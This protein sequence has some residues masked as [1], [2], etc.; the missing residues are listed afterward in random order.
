MQCER[1]DA[2]KFI[3]NA[4]F[5]SHSAT[6]L[7]QGGTCL[8]NCNSLTRASSREWNASSESVAVVAARVG[9]HLINS[10]APKWKQRT[11]S[12]AI[13]AD[14]RWCGDSL[15][16][17]IPPYCQQ[18]KRRP[19]RRRRRKADAVWQLS[20][21]AT[22][23]RHRRCA[24]ERVSR[25]H[26]LPAGDQIPAPE[27]S[28]PRRRHADTRRSVRGGIRSGT[29]HAEA[30]TETREAVRETTRD[31]QDA[32]RRQ[33]RGRRPRGVRCPARRQRRKNSTSAGVAGGLTT[34]SYPLPPAPTRPDVPA[35][36]RPEWQPRLT[37]R[38]ATRGRDTPSYSRDRDNTASPA[39][40]L[41]LVG[42]KVMARFGVTLQKRYDRFGYYAD[43][44][45]QSFVLIMK[46]VWRVLITKRNV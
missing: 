13:S 25:M 6:K 23:C 26:H 46:V 14:R 28:P 31:E 40:C 45:A 9:K 38:T 41:Q 32:A 33:A 35:P 39:S 19:R 34:G 2:F 5:E 11:E 10:A 18:G 22:K 8:L 42:T 24:R 20:S 30:R 27:T 44:V 36:T 3:W 16:N 1:H 21:S 29:W 4:S 17:A 37:G 7:T 12:V 43:L 15:R